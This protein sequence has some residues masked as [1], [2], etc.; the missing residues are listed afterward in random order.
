MQEAL[1]CAYGIC[2]VLW[3]GYQFCI[4][5]SAVCQLLQEFSAE[6]FCAW[7]VFACV[8]YFLLSVCLFLLKRTRTLQAL[9]T[10]PGIFGISCRLLSHASARG[11]ESLVGD[12]TA[13]RPWLVLACNQVDT[14]QS[15][16]PSLSL[17]FH[18]RPGFFFSS[19]IWRHFGCL[20]VL[21]YSPLCVN[22]HESQ[23]AFPYTPLPA[24]SLSVSTAPYRLVP[25]G[26]NPS[27]LRIH[28]VSSLHPTPRYHSSSSSSCLCDPHRNHPDEADTDTL[29]A[30]H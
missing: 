27:I 9:S 23:R 26:S 25:R 4:D 21:I 1:P 11:V 24:L 8:V 14:F 6:Q 17:L 19:V 13:P 7:T 22:V 16:S 3:T 12:R 2:A 5:L 20:L 15:L 30:P 10:S 28:F 29:F 18:F